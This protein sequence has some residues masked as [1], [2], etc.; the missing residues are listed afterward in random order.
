MDIIATLQACINALGGLKLRVDQEQEGNTARAVIRTL[1]DVKAE[2]ARREEERKA[3]EQS[4][5][6]AEE[7]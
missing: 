1:F 5:E 2:I 4:E 6:K 3:K 7:E